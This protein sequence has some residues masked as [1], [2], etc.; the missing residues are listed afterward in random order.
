MND[1]PNAPGEQRDMTEAVMPGVPIPDDTAPL[2]SVAIPPER[3]ARSAGWVL[4]SSILSS[5]SLGIV[6]VLTARELGPRG[7]GEIV[8]LLTVAIL[9]TMITSL[10]LNIGA[11]IHL[12]SPDE[13]V[14][15]PNFIGL[16]V[17]LSFAGGLVAYLVASLLL[18]LVGITMGGNRGALLT[19]YATSLLA[20]LFSRDMFIAFGQNKRSAT[21]DAL[22]NL[23]T[24][25]L[26]AGAAIGGSLTVNS[27]LG[28]FVA[29]GV[30]QVLL[31]AYFLKKD[32]LWAR[33]RL[34][35]QATKTLLRTGVPG[36][37]L[38]L[39]LALTYRL[40]RYLVGLFLG[41]G[42]VGIYAV[43]ATATEL[44][45]LPAY[46]IAQVFFHRLASGS[47]ATT[48]LKRVLTYAIGLALAGGIPLFIAA[49]WMVDHIFGPEFSGAVGPLRIL[50][51][52]E[53]GM[54]A[55]QVCQT[56]LAVLVSTA[57]AA[58]VAILGLGVVTI[59]DIVLIPSL[60]VE[61]AAIASVVAYAFMAVAAYR[62]LGRAGTSG[63]DRGST[64]VP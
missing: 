23:G 42:A 41:P 45:R 63:G 2:S 27:V 46:A 3:F 13:P 5:V 62:S 14:S 29:S 30:L 53:I 60:E 36:I 4:G 20:A 34:S 33:P 57:R 19:L 9:T 55:F 48:Q 61:G 44:L 21:M 52:A 26:V 15:L 17:V 8:L 10:G 38:N 32:R 64:L 16:S 11:R 37:A 22:G 35:R 24:L 7:R 18:P 51:L 56:A 25:A 12:V 39:G 40:D 28:Y 49:P 43:A 31:A 6:A 58:I 59:A 50:I 1:D 54:T 47:W